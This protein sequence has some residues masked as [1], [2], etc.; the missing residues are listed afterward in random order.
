MT[1]EEQAQ[2]AVIEQK[3]DGINHRLDDM[4]GTVA[5]TKGRLREVEDYI[6]VDKTKNKTTAWVKDNIMGIL[7]AI[8]SS[9]AVA[10]ILFRLGGG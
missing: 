7:S 3:V 1:V 4:N 6:L 9:V 8:I 5:R 10:L 2:L